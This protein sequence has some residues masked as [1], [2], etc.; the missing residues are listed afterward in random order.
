MDKTKI[1]LKINDI[2]C[3]STYIGLSSILWYLFMTGVATAQDIDTAMKLGAGYPMGPFELMDYIG[4]DTHKFVADGK[5]N[6]L[7]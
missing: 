3:G 4:L 7:S 1:F 6:F 2:I 5:I